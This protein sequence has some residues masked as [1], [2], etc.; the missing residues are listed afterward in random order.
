MA[1]CTIPIKIQRS[2]VDV[3]QG[4]AL[5][6]ARKASPRPGAGKCFFGAGPYFC[7]AFSAPLCP[8]RRSCREGAV[9]EGGTA[10]KR[11]CR[12]QEAKLPEGNAAPLVGER[13]RRG[14]CRQGSIAVRERSRQPGECRQGEHHC[15]RHCYHGS[16]AVRGGHCRQRAQPYGGAAARGHSGEG[17]KRKFFLPLSPPARA[18]LSDPRFAVKLRFFLLHACFFFPFPV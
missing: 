3:F 12:R 18:H 13:S 7:P 16:A 1:S 14:R 6:A 8:G 9:I 15:Q 10:V 11:E 17:G 2:S 5:S 4:A